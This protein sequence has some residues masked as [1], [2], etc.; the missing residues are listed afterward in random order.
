M[1]ES[2]QGLIVG[3]QL[4]LGKINV[5]NVKACSCQSKTLSTLT[6]EEAQGCSKGG[7]EDIERGG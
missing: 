1:H 6:K 7:C 3:V 4:K 5:T 2:T